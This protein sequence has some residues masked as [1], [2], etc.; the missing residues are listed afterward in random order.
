MTKE[1]Y[2]ATTVDPSDSYVGIEGVW[3]ASKYSLSDVKEELTKY[4]L[5]HYEK[6]PVFASEGE[7]AIDIHLVKIHN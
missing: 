3:D 5:E 6:E 4:S 1:V 7:F 2:V